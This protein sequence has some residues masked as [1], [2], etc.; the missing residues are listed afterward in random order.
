MR[1]LCQ[2]FVINDS[3]LSQLIN[4]IDRI[5]TN[6]VDLVIVNDISLNDIEVKLNEINYIISIGKARLDNT[7]KNI[8]VFE[9]DIIKRRAD[10]LR[11]VIDKKNSIL[12][13]LYYQK[14]LSYLNENSHKANA[15][16][17]LEKSLEIDP[18]YIPSLYKLT[19]VFYDEGNLK[20]SSEFMLIILNR[21]YPA[22]RI[23]DS[24][25]KLGN[26]LY[27]SFIINAENLNHQEKYSEAEN[28]LVTAAQ[29]C[30]SNN[31][32]RC[33]DNLKKTITDTKYGM[34][35]SYLNIAESALNTNH[36]DLAE[37]FIFSALS[38]KR[39]N[40]EYL[41]NFKDAEKMLEQIIDSYLQ[42]AANSIDKRNYT[43]AMKYFDKSS[44]L[45]DS[46]GGDDCN[47]KIKYGINSI[48]NN[49]YNEFIAKA[50][51]Y[52]KTGYSK[53]AEEYIN[54]ARS[55]NKDNL[56]DIKDTSHAENL[57][58]KIKYIQ[59]M[60]QIDEAENFYK[61]GD[62]ESV[63]K[64]LDIAD[65][66]EA[67]YKLDKYNEKD[68]LQKNAAK[69]LIHHII[70]SADIKIWGNDIDEAQNIQNISQNMQN[71][72]HLK[73]DTDV[74]KWINLLKEKILKKNCENDQTNYDVLVFKANNSIQM[75]EY[76][77]AEV[78]FNEAANIAKKTS[79]L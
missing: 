6:N 41:K 76:I 33:N 37:S 44:V 51:E 65:E 75:H 26:N 10:K 73:N 21:T 58:K 34:Y 3:L 67:K 35:R 46:L 20:K 79:C 61:A 16:K 4:N 7:R 72:Y 28:L 38:Y 66:L 2:N 64:S 32:I 54:K 56:N 15:R 18:L 62:Y 60:K 49:I 1:L 11:I 68:S 70:R 55:Y 50:D 31:V 59:Y 53:I 13:E 63:I 24:I 25:I 43:K 12:Q 69:P 42:T 48:K 29:F 27:N 17:Y 47:R 39:K 57:L 77:D 19:Q 45:C 52:F 8:I 36:S 78:F 74:T 23:Y 5:D 9:L 14:A 40:I 71:K 30:K 22:G